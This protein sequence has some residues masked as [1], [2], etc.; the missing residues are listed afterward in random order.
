MND[1][2]MNFSAALLCI[3]TAQLMLGMIF[4]GK[5]DTLPKYIVSILMSAVAMI[6]FGLIVERIVHII[7][8]L[9]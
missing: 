8:A 2:S 9:T 3:F 6:V 4:N 7:I 5:T 1:L